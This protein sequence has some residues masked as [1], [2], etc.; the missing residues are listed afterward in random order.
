MRNEY[1]FSK[2]KRGPVI[3]AD[4]NK[5]PVIEVLLSPTETCKQII[6]DKEGNPLRSVGT[7]QDITER[8]QNETIK[9]RIE[10]EI[11]AIRDCNQILLRATEEPVVRPRATRESR[12]ALR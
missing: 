12:Y 2:G 11:K 7:I 9:K 3:P 5:L 4:P 6:R 8:I 10:R 1:D